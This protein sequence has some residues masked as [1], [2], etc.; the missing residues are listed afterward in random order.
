DLGKDLV[1]LNMVKDITIKNGNINVVVELTTPAC[2]LKN[3]I[4]E[5]CISEIKKNLPEVNSVNIN[6]T[7]NVS[8]HFD[9]NSDPILSGIKN[10][11]AIASGKGGVGKS[12]V[13]VNLAIALAMDGAKVGL[14]DADIYGPSIP[15]MLGID[16]NP[17]IF[18]DSTSNK[19]IPIEKYGIKLMS[20]GFLIDDDSPVIWRGP[21]ASG[22]IKQFMSDVKWG[23]LD[24]LFFDLPPGTG[25]IQLT[26]VQT[27]PLTGAVIVTTPQDVS[28]ID[29]RKGLKMFGR[30]N[31]AVLGILENMS[32]FIAP[33]TGNRYDIFGSGGGEE[34]AK[35][36]GVKYL[37][38]LPLNPTIREAGDTG[39][40][41]LNKYPQLP[42]TKKIFEISRCLASQISIQNTNSSTQK[43]Q[44]EIDK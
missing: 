21:M 5:N 17:Q 40:S 9:T 25:D 19:M 8:S 44:I 7:S 3:T 32:Y 43:L 11:I 10:T 36:L 42:E 39:V 2:P 24:Y 26:L 30:V 29:A 12:T 13:A 41:I 14:I 6:M 18:Q 20:I 23:E 15:L 33:D 31:V 28:L 34:L 1:S 16:R 37:G 4:K 35:N 38:G 22:A 27:I